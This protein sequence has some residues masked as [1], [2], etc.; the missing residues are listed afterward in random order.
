M[1]AK[2]PQIEELLDHRDEIEASVSA[3]LGH[4]WGVSEIQDLAEK[5]SHP[6]ALTRGFRYARCHVMGRNELAFA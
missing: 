6:S 2:E 4:E 1:T 5:S 3:Y